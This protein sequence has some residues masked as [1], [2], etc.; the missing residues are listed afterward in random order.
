MSN[1][2]VV[3]FHTTSAAMKAEK[4]LTEAGLEV[5][6]IP[7]PRDYSSDCGIAIRFVWNDDIDIN[8]LLASENVET[9]GVYKLR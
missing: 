3:V 4:V 7:T 8:E 5:K 1:F 9:A 2:G 6:P